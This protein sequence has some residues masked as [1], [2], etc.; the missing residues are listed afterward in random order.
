MS[1]KRYLEEQKNTHMEHA[2]DLVLNAGVQ[3]A[4]MAINYFQGVRDMLAG[5]SSYGW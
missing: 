3:G 5:H 2:E 4:R 1:F